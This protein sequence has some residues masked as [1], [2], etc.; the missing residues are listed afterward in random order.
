MT[1]SVADDPAGREIAEVSRTPRLKREN[2]DVLAVPAGPNRTWS[3]DFMLNRPAG[4]R[5]FRALNVRDDFNRT[6]R[7]EWL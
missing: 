7:H 5:S 2:P 1:P 3:T 6:V 4:D